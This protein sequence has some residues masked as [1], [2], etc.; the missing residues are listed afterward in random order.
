MKNVAHPAAPFHAARPFVCAIG[1]ALPSVLMIL[2]GEG[3]VGWALA[4]QKHSTAV[5]PFPLFIFGRSSNHERGKK[6]TERY[7]FVV[8]VVQF[9]VFFVIRG[10]ANWWAKAQC[11]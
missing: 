9:F 7:F 5:H 1:S 4:H 11:H 3:N 10:L 2:P 8:F 6:G